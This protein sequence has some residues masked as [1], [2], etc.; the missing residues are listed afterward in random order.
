LGIK[1]SSAP[2]KKSTNIAPKNTG[3]AGKLGNRASE[4]EDAINKLR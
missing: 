3:L 1:N 2:P 4:L